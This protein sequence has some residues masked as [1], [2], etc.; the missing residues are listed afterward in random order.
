MLRE[1]LRQR[2]WK[3]KEADFKKPVEEGRNK[4]TGKVQQFEQMFESAL[5]NATSDD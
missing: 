4:R 2:L 3:Y 1:I 5:H